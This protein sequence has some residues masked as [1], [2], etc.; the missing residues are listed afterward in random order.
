M[1]AIIKICNMIF[2]QKI[3]KNG[4]SGVA[5]TCYNLIGKAK[6]ILACQNTAARRPLTDFYF[7]LWN[8]Y[9]FTSRNRENRNKN[10]GLAQFRSVA[11]IHILIKYSGVRLMKCI[12]KLDYT[13]VCVAIVSNPI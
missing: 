4:R 6:G 11:F 8:T 9:T 13:M 2:G 10:F 1:T 12:C 3:S 5:T 7:F